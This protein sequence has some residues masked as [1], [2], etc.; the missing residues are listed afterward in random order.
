M[1]EIPISSDAPHFSQENH[2][3]GRT[4]MIEFEW[5]ERENY[6]V[7]HVYN[8]LEQPIALGLR[9]ST[10]W[11]IFVDQSTRTVFLLAAKNPNAELS[12]KTL[13]SDFALVAHEHEIV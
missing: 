2:I 10:G 12:L 7:L 3:F 6:W 1:L 5:I 9:V 8:A 11:P 4:Y 13:H